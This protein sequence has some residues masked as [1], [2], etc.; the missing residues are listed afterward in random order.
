MSRWDC[1]TDEELA[2]WQAQAL[3]V[4]TNFA[5]WNTDDPCVDCLASFSE[6]MRA[7]GRCNGTPGE[8]MSELPPVRPITESRRESNRACQQRY[9]EK[10][11]AELTERRRAYF[12]ER[13][14][15]FVAAR[16]MTDIVE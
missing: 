9:R 10:H 2:L 5:K 16:T 11:R 12:S 13:W 8:S 1:M 15:R 7:L 3:Y 14:R 6:E 4:R